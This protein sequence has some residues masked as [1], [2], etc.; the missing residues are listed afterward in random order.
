MV[1]RLAIAIRTTLSKS[2]GGCRAGGLWLLLFADFVRTLFSFAWFGS[3]LF[4]YA[5]LEILCISLVLVLGGSSS[6]R[7]WLVVGLM[8]VLVAVLGS[9]RNCWR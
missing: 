6:S 4:S 7:W 1:R 2:P 8:V 5:N 3:V 9:F